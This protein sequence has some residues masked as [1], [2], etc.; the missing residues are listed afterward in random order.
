MQF[1][2]VR[3]FLFIQ[4]CYCHWKCMNWLLFLLDSKLILCSSKIWFLPYDDIC[5]A[6][7]KR[8]SWKIFGESL[9][10]N[11][12][13]LF[14]PV[15][16]GISNFILD[17][18]IVLFLSAI[19]NNVIRDIVNCRCPKL[20]YLHRLLSEIGYFLNYLFRCLH[21]FKYAKILEY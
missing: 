10:L 6:M 3:D 18:N 21:H 17:S 19:C 4:F 20:F 9:S 15:L 2:P 7:Q 14:F 5:F 11:N 12:I 8:W 13:A 1:F 16:F